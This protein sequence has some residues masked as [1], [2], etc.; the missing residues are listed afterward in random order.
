MA[1]L[2]RESLQDD[3]VQADMRS[4]RRPRA[5]DLALSLWTSFGYFESPGDDRVVLENEYE[6]LSEDGQFVIDPD[7]HR[8]NEFLAGYVCGVRNLLRGKS[9]RVLNRH[10]FYVAYVE[11]CFQ[12]VYQHKPTLR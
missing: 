6:S 11:V 5:Y 7:N 3:V 1:R 12:F 10:E 8:L 9:R 2:E 4:F